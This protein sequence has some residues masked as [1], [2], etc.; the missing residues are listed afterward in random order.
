MSSAKRAGYG[1]LADA[2]ERLQEDKARESEGEEEKEEGKIRRRR[3]EGGREREEGGEGR[4]IEVNRSARRRDARRFCG[5]MPACVERRCWGRAAGY[6]RR[7]VLTRARCETRVNETA[8]GNFEDVG[9][10]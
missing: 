10:G 1:A 9:L 5:A 3:G 2:E 8:A 6:A 7:N 4:W